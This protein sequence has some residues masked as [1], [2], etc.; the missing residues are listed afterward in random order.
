MPTATYPYV[1]IGPRVRLWFSDPTRA[2]TLYEYPKH[3]IQQYERNGLNSD[4]HSGEMYR[5]YHQAKLG[6]FKDKRDIALLLS[7]DEFHRFDGRWNPK[8]RSIRLTPLLMLV[9]NLPPLMRFLSRNMFLVGFIPGPAPTE[10]D[11]FLEPLVRELEELGEGIS[12][13]DASRN[14][15]RFT[16]RCYLVAVASDM[17]QKAK[18]LHTVGNRGMRYC[19]ICKITSLHKVG[20]SRYCPHRA[21]LN[22]PAAV[23]ERETLF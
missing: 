19:E 18:I 9:Y 17:I 16:L 20:S 21:P 6:Q 7:M 8:M 23:V 15:T 2:L 1:D 14:Y 10:F 22:A 13:V 12:A 4:F 3:V 5:E 11:T